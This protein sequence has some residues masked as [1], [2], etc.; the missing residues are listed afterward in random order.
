VI[1]GQNNLD[2]ALQLIATQSITYHQFAGRTTN[3]AGIQVP[4]FVP[5]VVL[6]RCSVQPVPASKY[7]NLGLDF[8]RRYVQVWAM[9][10]MYGVA[11]SRAPDE[12]TWNGQRYQVTQETGWFPQ[13][14]WSSVVAV[15]MEGNAAH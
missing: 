14:G 4:T 10:D 15:E 3:A 5:D 13:D 12:F 8:K 7:Q 6:P 11:R 2:L 9:F 1:P